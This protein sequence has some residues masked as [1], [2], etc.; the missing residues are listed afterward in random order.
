MSDQRI[1]EELAHL[2]RLTEELS[3]VV[4]RQGGEIDRLTRR[5]QMLMERAASQETEGAGGVVFGDARPPHY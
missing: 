5:M 3:D 4:A 1:E 2:R